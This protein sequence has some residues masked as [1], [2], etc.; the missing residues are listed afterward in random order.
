MLDA[1]HCD[2][3]KK[4]A[5]LAKLNKDFGHFNAA[6]DPA[7]QA[8]T[9]ASQ[10]AEAKER[11]RHQAELEKIA[12]LSCGVVE[13]TVG[14]FEKVH[15]PKANDMNDMEVNKALLTRVAECRAT[16]GATEH[17]VEEA[18]H[19]KPCDTPKEESGYQNIS[20]CQK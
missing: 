16:P 5:Y 18:S 15:L 6:T 2:P 11:E 7:V 9:K 3:A 14:S 17:H 19:K 4:G 10:A 12:N 13:A 1:G 20:Q 8:A